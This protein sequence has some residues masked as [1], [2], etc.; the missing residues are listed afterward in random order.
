M[1]NE[2]EEILNKIINIGELMKTVTTVDFGIG[3]KLLFV[4]INASTYMRALA[5]T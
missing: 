5:L 1:Q 2:Q 4:T 3:K